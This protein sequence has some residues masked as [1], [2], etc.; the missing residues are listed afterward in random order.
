M[1]WWW[2]LA[3]LALLA[4]GLTALAIDIDRFLYGGVSVLRA[5][6]SPSA[7]VVSPDDQ[8]IY[9]A[10]STDSITPVSAVTGKTGRS[11]PIS[12]G[13][14]GGGAYLG[15]LAITPDGRTL[16]ATVSSPTAGAGL[17][18]ARIDLRTGQETGQVRVPGGVAD[19]VLSRDGKTLY[20]AGA[21]N[22]L[23]AVDTATDR[24]KRTIP[25]PGYLANEGAM[26]LSPD[27]GTLYVATSDDGSVASTG[28]VT[29]VNLRTGAT[30]PAVY[31]GWEPTSLALTP[32]GRTLYAAIDGIDGEAGQVAPNRVAVIDTAT[33]R[34]RASIPWQVPPLYVVMAP[35]GRTVWV[36]SIIGGRV[37]TA[38]NT[39]TPV[40]V[41]S[42]Q[43]GSSFRTSG[44]L[45]KEADGPSGVAMS[46]DG[47]ALYV[48]VS[49]GIET[50]R[51]H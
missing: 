48:T 31:V 5:G 49:T 32:D 13:T 26:A 43:P 2:I 39:V 46:P 7:L 28:A 17:P 18:L 47:H 37:S 20:A 45:N 8:T 16:F 23:L 24:T 30:G 27:G 21:G 42:D 12:G 3:W 15:E 33:G 22:T 34:V 29:P 1:V 50:F 44:W 6:V 14:P 19:F 10:N 4:V 41:A 40:A 51:I 35:N 25:V 36:V 11:I 38:D 9:L